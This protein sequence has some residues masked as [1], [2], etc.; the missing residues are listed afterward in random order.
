MLAIPQKL[1]VS[2]YGWVFQ[3]HSPY[4]PLFNYYINLLDEQGILH[5]IVKAYEAGPQECPDYN[6]LPLGFDSCIAAF[7]VFL[8]G[9]GLGFVLFILE[10]FIPLMK[11]PGTNPNEVSAFEVS[12]NNPN[13]IGQMANI[14]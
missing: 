11:K 7:I 5:K 13:S 6:G 14:E 9:A 12:E 10:I 4:L 1:S 3:K 2:N 8:T